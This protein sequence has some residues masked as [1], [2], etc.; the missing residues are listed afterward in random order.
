MNPDATG[1]VAVVTLAHG[2]HDHLRGLLA[3]LR[4]GTRVPDVLVVVAM[5]DEDI[6]AI[7]RQ[8]RAR[9]QPRRRW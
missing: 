3:G 5:D 7:A 8:R 4:A 9:H 1:R 2:R 6:A